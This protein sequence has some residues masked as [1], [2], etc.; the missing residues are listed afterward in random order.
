MPVGGHY[1]AAAAVWYAIC[2]GKY[3]CSDH[4]NRDYVLIT[5]GLI[6]QI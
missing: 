2:I 1:E 6:K 3:T 5:E 4:Q